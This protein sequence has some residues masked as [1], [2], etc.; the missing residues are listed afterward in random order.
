MHHRLLRAL[1]AIAIAAFTASSL[2][3]WQWTDRLARVDSM[4]VHEEELGLAWKAIAEGDLEAAHEAGRVMATGD[5]VPG[6][7]KQTL[8]ELRF[9]AAHVA[10]AKD[11]DTAAESLA[12]MTRACAKCH[13]AWSV[14]APD[15]P[16]SG[17]PGDA[18]WLALSFE[19]PE[20]WSQ[21]GI[22]AAGD[23]DA[24]RELAA[25][26]LADS[27]RKGSTSDGG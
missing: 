24:R 14:D 7:D 23:W 22:E 12:E 20:L 17:D 26:A 6:V 5:P 25:E 13:N 10:D 8:A 21:A 9:A 15:H 3:C 18:L 27:A 2:G 4:V 19:S 16:L 1:G 11:L